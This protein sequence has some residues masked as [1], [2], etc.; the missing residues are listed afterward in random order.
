MKIASLSTLRVIALVATFAIL[1]TP[2]SAQ[3]QAT[4]SGQVTDAQGGA[5]PGAVVVA[6]HLPTGATLEATTGPD[7]RFSLS[8]VRP[9]G[10]YRITVNM[11]GFATQERRDVFATVGDTTRV[12]FELPLAGVNELV[13][14]TAGTALAR[15]E[16]RSAPSIMDVV[17]ADS[18]GRFPDANAAEALRRIPGVSMEIDQGEGRFVV[19]RGIDASLNNVTLNGQVIGTP[20][21]FGTRGVSMDAVPADLIS[22]LEVVKAVRPDMDANAI[23]ASINIATLGRLRHAR[24]VPVRIAAVRLQRHERPRAVYRERLV[25]PRARRVAT[26]GPRARRELL[27]AS[28]RIGVVSG[29]RHLG[30]LR[31]LIRPAES[32]VLPLRSQPAPPGRQCGGRIPA[33]ESAFALRSVS[34]TIVSRT[35]KA[36]S[37]PSSTSR[38]ER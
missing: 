26:L 38:A 5:L 18:V 2:V 19:V 11:A 3:P 22:R 13:S 23:G 12:D 37:R 25:R 28:L 7:G 15:D 31:R 27:A 8:G 20:A 32:G 24:R 30:R 33:D 14:V 9:G 1:H 21:E 6:L 10:P 36:A 34:I 29:G 4:L 16:K 35:R 17:S